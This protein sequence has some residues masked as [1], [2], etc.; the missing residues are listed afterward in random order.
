MS[1]PSHPVVG[2]LWLIGC[3]H[4]TFASLLFMKYFLS[5]QAR[6]YVIWAATVGTL[7]AR[8]LRDTHFLSDN[9]PSKPSKVT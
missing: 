2:D 7:F 5:R 3:Q 1:I 9:F 6:L 8:L 4:R